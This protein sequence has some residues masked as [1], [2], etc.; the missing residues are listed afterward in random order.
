M[1]FRIPTTSEKNHVYN[2]NIGYHRRLRP[3][4]HARPGRNKRIRSRHSLWQTQRAHRG[5]HTGGTES[6]L[7]G[8][9][10]AG[11]PDQPQRGQ[12]SRKHLRAQIPRRRARHRHQRL[13]FPARRLRPRP[14]RHPRPG[15][16][17]HAPARP[18]LLWGGTRRAHLCGGTVL[19][20]P[21]G[22]VGRRRTRGRRDHPS[23]RRV[24]HHRRP[25]LLHQSR[26]EHLPRLG[27]VHRRHDRLAR[28]LP[29]AR[30][31]NVLRRHGARHRLRRVAHQRVA[32]HRRDGHRN[33]EAEHAH[34]AGSRS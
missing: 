1:A 21:F 3:L 17:Q 26:I 22:P 25:A 5:W 27:H 28:S 12:L 19:P 33:P 14:H 32:R 2:R 16:R 4:L 13:R 6:R 11:T 9:A 24:H 30:S 18:L 29:G 10:R 31:R 15:L 7:P 34:G 8:A 20:R 23:R